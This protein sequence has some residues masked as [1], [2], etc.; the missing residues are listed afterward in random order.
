MLTSRVR[1]VHSV[2]CSVF[3]MPSSYWL[4]GVMTVPSLFSQKIT[5]AVLF[6]TLFSYNNLRCWLILSDLLV[7]LFQLFHGTYKVLLIKLEL[8]CVNK[9]IIYLG[10]SN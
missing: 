10:Y 2:M 5:D 6:V 4:T 1:T 8:C 9:K 7:R 3:W